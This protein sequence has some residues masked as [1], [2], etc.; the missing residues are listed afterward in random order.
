MANWYKAVFR[1]DDPVLR[2]EV[3]RL[4][5]ESRAPAAQLEEG[6]IV[7]YLRDGCLR[8]GVVRSAPTPGRPTG[9][10]DTSGREARVRRDKIVLISPERIPTRKR[11]ECLLSLCQLDEDRR[12][13]SRAIDMRVLW[14][15]VCDEIHSGAGDGERA[16]EELVALYF[17]QKPGIGDGAALLRALWEGDWFARRGHR[18]VPLSAGVVSARQSELRRHAHEDATEEALGQWLRSV[19]DGLPSEPPP[20]AGRA[21]SLLEETALYGAQSS[22]A[23][24]AAALMNLAHLHGPGAAFDLLV[25]LGHWHADENLDLHRGAI[26]TRFSRH[27]LEQAAEMAASSGKTWRRSGWRFRRVWWGRVMGLQQEDGRCL[28]AFRM[29][30]RPGGYSLS[31]YFAIPGRL[32]PPG[33]AVDEEARTRGVSLDLPDRII[34]LLPDSVAQSACLHQGVVEPVLAVEVQLGGDMEPRGGCVSLRRIR[35]CRILTAIEITQMQGRDGDV[36]P[37]LR[38]VRVLRRRRLG[39]G[40]V[41]FPPLP[42]LTVSDHSRTCQPEPVDVGPDA[43]EELGL[44]ASEVCGEFCARKQIPAIYRVQEAPGERPVD[45]D[46]TDLAIAHEQA[47][48]MPRGL[49]QVEPGI[50]AGLGLPVCVAMDRPLDSYVDLVMQQQLAEVAAR[51]QPRYTAHEMQRVL[52]DTAAAREAGVDV[53]RSARRYWALKYLEEWEGRDVE[54]T[55]VERA[56]VGYVVQFAEVGTKGYVRT[57][58]E[59][60]AAPGDRV[61]VRLE[62]VSARRDVLRLTKATRVRR[63]EESVPVAVSEPG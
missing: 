40:G 11:E 16:V 9:I 33:S 42:R 8:C 58:G 51:G 38:L 53:A 52:T 62:R 4:V 57:G 25:R 12:R 44:L 10:L 13:A 50:H 49:L 32:V 6:A 5:G 46:A 28:H 22:R 34:P 55:V 21:V 36:R 7:E 63:I 56:G 30:R 24:E 23:A 29:V 20:G 37:I 18:W 60:W 43:L 41:L 26:P 17:G 14:E 54:V 3:A 27:A 35:P 19:A 48:R 61:C 59:L 47:R 45:G 39:G 31:V 15:A 2:A 1:R